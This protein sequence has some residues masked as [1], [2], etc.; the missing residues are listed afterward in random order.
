MEKNSGLPLYVDPNKTISA[1]HSQGNELA[2]GMQDNSE[3]Q[4]ICALWFTKP[5]WGSALQM[6]FYK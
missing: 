3:L 5:H 1:P 6:I 4:W 2:F